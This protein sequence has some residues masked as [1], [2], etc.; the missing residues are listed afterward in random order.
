LNGVPNSVTLTLPSAETDEVRAD[1]GLY[2][3]DKWTI[4]RKLT[5]NYGVRANYLVT[6]WP[7]EILPANPF[8]PAATFPGRSTFL[9]WKDL[10]PR[11]GVAYDPTGKGKTSLRFSFARYD[12][13]QL[14]A[15][16]GDANPLAAISTTETLTW[17]DLAGTGTRYEPGT[18][19]FIPGQLGPSNNVNFGKLAQ[20]TTVD[21]NLQSGWFK[22][23]FVDEFILGV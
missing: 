19:T 5:M 6:G 7:K 14:L 10:S 13:P 1:L 2:F 4:K 17:R 11:A 18:F 22:Q 15:L 12:V 21:P 9:N 23:P 8:T 3:Q 20:T 16:T